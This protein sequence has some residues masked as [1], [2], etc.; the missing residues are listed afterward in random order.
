MIYSSVV[1]SVERPAVN[2]KASRFEP[3]R[4]SMNNKVLTDLR[5]DI[6]ATRKRK[7]ITQ[8]QLAEM[9]GTKHSSISRFENGTYLPNLI[10]LSKLANSLDSEV[11]IN[12]KNKILN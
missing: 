7:Q 3:W 6:K 8:C 12:F 1:Q 11:V 9:I 5:T 4:G 2:R 10:F